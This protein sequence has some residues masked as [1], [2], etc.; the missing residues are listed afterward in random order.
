MKLRNSLTGN[1]NGIM[2]RHRAEIGYYSRSRGA[3][4]GEDGEL[5]ALPHVKKKHKRGTGHVSSRFAGRVARPGLVGAGPWPGVWRR[6][7]WRTKWAG[8]PRAAGP[9]AHGP[10]G[11]HPADCA[12]WHGNEHQKRSNDQR[13]GDGV[14]QRA[15]YR[16]GHR[17]LHQAGR[18]RR[19]HRGGRQEPRCRGESYVADRGHADDRAASRIGRR[20]IGGRHPRPKEQLRFRMPGGG[21]A[22]AVPA[23]KATQ[24]AEKHKAA[25]AIRCLPPS[26]FAAR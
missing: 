9:S 11:H 25:A 24:K 20:G 15:P 13:C 10:A 18:R 1:E 14:N 12:G 23:E 22:D 7:W 4:R 26:S 19:V 16:L 8:Q 5:G 3:C 21:G 6:V 17:R 2:D